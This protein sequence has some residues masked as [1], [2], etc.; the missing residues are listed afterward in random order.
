MRVRRGWV[1]GNKKWARIDSSSVSSAKSRSRPAH[2]TTSNPF[3]EQELAEAFIEF[4][5]FSFHSPLE[6]YPFRGLF[7]GCFYPHPCAFHFVIPHSLPGLASVGRFQS[8]C[9]LMTLL[10][11][12]MMLSSCCFAASLSSPYLIP[13]FPM[14]LLFY[15]GLCAIP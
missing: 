2:P 6:L 5:L 15:A 3:E 9:L 7:L 12:D 10:E 14:S 13:T 4:C 8:V 11:A 1:K